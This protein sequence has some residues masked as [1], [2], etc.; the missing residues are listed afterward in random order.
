MALVRPRTPAPATGPAY[1]SAWLKGYDSGYNGREKTPP[2]KTENAI[3]AAF[4]RY[5]N[6]GYDAGAAD[7]GTAP[8]TAPDEGTPTAPATR[9]PRPPVLSVVVEADGVAVE[10]RLTGVWT[11]YIDTQYL[12]VYHPFYSLSYVDRVEKLFGL[13]KLPRDVDPF[14]S[15]T[16]GRAIAEGVLAAILNDEGW[17]SR[18]PGIDVIL[19]S[20]V[21]DLVVARHVAR[22]E[23]PHGGTE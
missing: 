12:G 18:R 9:E 4:A 8:E 16:F 14:R 20:D 15:E 3:S 22:K 23:Q 19:N 21:G 10:A 5:W 7:R 17:A 1:Q 2:Y 13:D 11:F 6:E